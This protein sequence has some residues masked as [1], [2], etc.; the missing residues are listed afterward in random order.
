MSELEEL[1]AE[2]ERL[3]G[4]LAAL[5]E[6]PQRLLDLTSQRCMEILEDTE[7]RPT[8][9]ELNVIRQLLRDQG[10]VDLTPGDTPINHLSE[11]YPFT[12]PSTEPGSV[13]G[14]REAQD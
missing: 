2:N 14:V 5:Q 13:Y 1:R 10:I 3:R 12:T 6:R 4:I 7:R 9:A 8:A 11:N